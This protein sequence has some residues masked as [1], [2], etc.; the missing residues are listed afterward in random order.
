M[1]RS[2]Q[3][4]HFTGC[5]L[6]PKTMHR[7]CNLPALCDTFLVNEHCILNTATVI[8]KWPQ[9]IRNHSVLPRLQ[10]FRIWRLK[11]FASQRGLGSIL[12]SL[13]GT[14]LWSIGFLFTT[15]IPYKITSKPRQLA[16]G[17][18]ILS[19]LCIVQKKKVVLNYYSLSVE[20]RERMR[21]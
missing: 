9:I 6:F 5:A 10:I 8:L 13:Y 20:V 14:I 19:I 1:L 18:F 11:I 4:T 7:T 17:N 15:P 16:T 12:V 3:R 21:Y 2:I